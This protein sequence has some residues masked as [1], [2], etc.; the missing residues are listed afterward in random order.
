MQTIEIDFEVFKALTARRATEATTYND[1]LRELLGLDSPPAQHRADSQTS[2]GLV[3]KGVQ[4]PDG[5]SFRATYGGAMHFG[6][7]EGGELVVNGVRTKSPS[8]AARVITGNNVN[9]WA[10]WECR[11]PGETRWRS[12]K[13]LRA[14]R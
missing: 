3:R 14:S 13:S 2:T 7:V 10:F 12:I 8:E 9:G 11:F 1:V 5:T 6:A 4:F